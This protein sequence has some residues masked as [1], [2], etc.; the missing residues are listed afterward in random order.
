MSKSDKKK[1]SWFKKRLVLAFVFL[2]LFVG[3]PSIFYWQTMM[4]SVVLSA[5]NSQYG[6]TVKYDEL[7]LNLIPCE[8]SILFPRLMDSLKNLMEP[9]AFADEVELSISTRKALRG[10]I[11]IHR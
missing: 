4:M 7:E 11:D 9:I 6:I 1:W 10:Q 3:L 5:L 8:I 2:V